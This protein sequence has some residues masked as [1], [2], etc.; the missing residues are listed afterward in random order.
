VTE[1]SFPRMH[2]R[3]QRFTLGRPRSFTV[4]EDRVLFLRSAAGD[5]RVHD[6]WVLDLPSGDE[7]RMTDARGLQ[8]GDEDLTPQERA[9]R[10]RLREGGSGIVAYGADEAGHQAAFTLGGT[11]WVVDTD[12]GAVQA[13]QTDGPA[14]DPRLSADGTRVAAVVD[15]G[16]HVGEVGDGVLRP[17]VTEDG[18]SWGLAEFVAAE[19]M[20]RTRG[21]WWHPDGLR[22]LVARVD[23]RAV[24]VWHIGDPAD[25]ARP[26]VEHRYPAAGTANADVSL[27]S[28][29]AES[30]DRTEVQ[31]DREAYPYLAQVT[32]TDAGPA[33]LQVQSRDQRTWDVLSVDDAGRSNLLR[34]DTDDTWLDLVSGSPMWAEGRLA[35]VVDLPAGDGGTRTLLVDDQVLSPAGVQVRR[36]A[37]VVGRHLWMTFSADDPT[38]I[39]V[40]HVDL[41]SGA[42]EVV[43]DE[44]G[45]HDVTVGPAGAVVASAT[46]A[47]PVVTYELIPADRTTDRIEIANLQLVPSLTPRV[48]LLVLGER[49][50]RAGL[51]RP[52]GDGPWPVLLLPYG[53][54]HAQRVLQSSAAFLTAKWFADHGFAVLVADGRGT[55]GRG[56][57]FERAVAGDL[58]GPP[59]QD[60]VDALH[61]AAEIE[62]RLDLTRVGI[63]G[64][65]FGG[66][67]AAVAV[68]RRP[69]VF[70]GAVAGAPVTQWGL[71]DTHYTERY[72]GD[73]GTSADNY[74]RSDLVGPDGE[75][76]GAVEPPDPDR[77][78]RMLIIHGLADDNVVAAHSLRLSAA[79]L[80]AGRPHEFLPLS[81]VTHMTPQEVV[82]ERLLLHQLRFLQESL[83]V[84]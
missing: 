7:R 19:E 13:L 52:A 39:L 5:D 23:E 79:L 9:R 22:L 67:L 61:T 38:S 73:P 62:P 50:L 75:L 3:S 33:L 76:A 55:P 8:V 14:F 29:D 64:W 25:P 56:P 81:G 27:W 68:L 11:V 18:V 17:L 53:G 1:V 31:W 78:P 10:E 36:V 15:G 57:V 47:D 24:D 51:L 37:G 49:A 65:S 32:L 72:L 44:P 34:N 46:L 26:V 41:D 77:P 20:Q 54:P 66:Y 63:S 60:Q 69:D 43:T 45:V 83:S 74:R 12:S 16:L 59:L 35:V 6:L 40:G 84:S 71:Y 48:E 2:A 70:H 30:G 28:V 4:A 80:A 58:A 82:A 42:L 21:F